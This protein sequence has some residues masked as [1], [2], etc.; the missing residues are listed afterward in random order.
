MPDFFSECAQAFSP[1]LVF[2]TKTLPHFSGSVS[3][4]LGAA[5]FGW[6]KKLSP[7]FA[8]FMSDRD[9]SAGS[10]N[11]QLLKALRNSD[12]CFACLTRENLDSEWIHFEAGAVALRDRHERLALFTGTFPRLQRAADCGRLRLWKI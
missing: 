5:L 12:G 7:S 10:W 9:I 6:L 3:K 8:P 11:P 2:H 4:V 1:P